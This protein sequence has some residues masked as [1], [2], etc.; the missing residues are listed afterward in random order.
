MSKTCHGIFGTLVTFGRLSKPGS[1]QRPSAIWHMYCTLGRFDAAR[2]DGRRQ[3][4]NFTT[5]SLVLYHVASRGQC[6]VS[7][8]GG[9]WSTTTYLY[10]S[11]IVFDVGAGTAT[12]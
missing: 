3:K 9:D 10:G 5:Q 4:G 6:G 7:G 11:I 8:E 2:W 1:S 12:I